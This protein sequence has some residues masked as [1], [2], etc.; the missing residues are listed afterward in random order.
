MERMLASEDETARLIG[1]FHLIREGFYDECLGRRVDALVSVHGPARTIAAKLAALHLP[2]AE[3]ADRARSMLVNSFNDEEER[4]RSEAADCFRHI[5]PDDFHR[6]HD[7][8][9]AFIGSAAYGKH[10]WALLHALESATT[11][12]TELVIAASE[13]SL[14]IW[15]GSSANSAHLADLHSLMPLLRAAYEGCREEPD[16]RRRILDTIDRMLELSVHGVDQIISA[17]ERL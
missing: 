17:H 10:D 15:E 8:A 5:R 12:V 4:V 2:L 1:T 9:E 16:L 6:Y 13:R 14:Q 3:Y 11:D 7:I